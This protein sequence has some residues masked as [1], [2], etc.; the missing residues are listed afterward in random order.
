LKYPA[1]RCLLA[2]LSKI[3]VEL[4]DLTSPTNFVLNA[5][6]RWLTGR[7]KLKVFWSVVESVTI[8]VVDVFMV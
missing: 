1:V 2:T 6:T 5:L 4:G 3:S 8:D 7:P